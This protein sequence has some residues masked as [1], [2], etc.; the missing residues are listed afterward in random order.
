MAQISPIKFSKELQK[1]LFPD[2]SFYKKSR[3]ET[4]IGPDVEN[5]EIPVSGDVGKAKSGDPSSL[6]LIVLEREDTKKSYPVEQLYTDPYLV[7]REEQIVLNYNKLIDVASALALSINERAGDIA[8]TNW[9]AVLSSN[10]VRTTSTAT[11]SSTVTGTTGT[12]KRITKTDMIG[13]RTKFNKM[14]L[15][16]LGRTSMWGILTPEMVEDL[17]LIPEFVDYDKTGELSKLRNGEIAYIMGFNLAMRN[18]TIGSAGVMYSVDASTKRTVDEALTVTDNAAAIFW[19]TSMVRHAEG[20][21]ATYI[22]R[23]KPEYLGGTLLSSVVRFGATF[24]RPDE[25]GIVALVET[26]GA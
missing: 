21:A 6:P 1:Q 13:V 22:D 25:K 15:P 4:G 12:R 7:R 23:G 11:R 24:D 10:I 3:T 18:N 20:N 16:S 8:A 26:N 14:N 5:V 19:H 17:L 2:N 9:G